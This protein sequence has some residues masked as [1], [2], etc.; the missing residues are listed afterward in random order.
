MLKF[1]RS[2]NELAE[3][4]IVKTELFEKENA[5]EREIL[6]KTFTIKKACL[7]D[8]NRSFLEILANDENSLSTQAKTT[9]PLK[10]KTPKHNYASQIPTSARMSNS[11]IVA[12]IESKLKVEPATTKNPKRRRMKSFLDFRHV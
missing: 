7:L 12:N 8:G 11:I 10:L 9:T 5:N 3:L 2:A 4:E 1:S 6:Y